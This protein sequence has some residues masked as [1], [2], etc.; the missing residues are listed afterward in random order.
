[1]LPLANQENYL[2]Q[3]MQSPGQNEHLA[4]VPLR[5]GHQHM[6]VEPGL[7]LATVE[8]Y[9]CQPMQQLGQSAPRMSIRLGQLGMEDHYSLLEEAMDTLQPHRLAARGRSVQLGGHQVNIF[10]VLGMAAVPL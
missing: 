8:K 1:M 10:G 9:L 3:Q 2:R 5:F 4:L 6:L 7:P